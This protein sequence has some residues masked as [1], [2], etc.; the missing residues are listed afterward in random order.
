MSQK[1]KVGIIGTGNISTYHMSDIIGLNINV[2]LL[3]FVIL[4]KIKLKA[5]KNIV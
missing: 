5:L 2:K 3:L 4:M 1:I